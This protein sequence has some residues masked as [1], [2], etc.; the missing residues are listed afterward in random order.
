M[1]ASQSSSESPSIE[2]RYPAFGGCFTEESNKMK[3][4]VGLDVEEEVAGLED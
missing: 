3:C 4:T 1:R 2:G